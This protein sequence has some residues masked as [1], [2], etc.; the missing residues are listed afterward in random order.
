MLTETMRSIKNHFAKDKLT[1]RLHGVEQGLFKL[2]VGTIE[3]KNT[4]LAGQYIAITGSIL[5]NGVYKVE[6]FDNGTIYLLPQTTEHPTWIKPTG[7]ATAYNFPD[8][9]TH[10]GKIWLCLQDINTIEPTYPDSTGVWW[11]EIASIEIQDPTTDEEFQG[12]IYSLHVPHD[13]IELVQKIKV[14]SESKEGQQSNVVSQSFGI[15]SVSFGTTSNGTR[16]GWQ[17]AFSTDLNK[18]RRMTADIEV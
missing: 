9:V 17:S 14:F 15:Q 1:G 13:F 7:V 4:Y 11:D 2:Q 18:Y 10:K 5:N 6:K 16:A 3:V 8:K 12:S